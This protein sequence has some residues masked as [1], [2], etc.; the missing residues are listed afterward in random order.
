M[1][2]EEIRGINDKKDVLDQL[3]PFVNDFW[4][5][6][7]ILSLSLSLGHLQFLGELFHWSKK[8]KK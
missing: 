2:N 4:S 3:V 6:L 5:S 1:E 8:A 7:I